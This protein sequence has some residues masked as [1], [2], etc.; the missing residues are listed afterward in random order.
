MRERLRD[1]GGAGRE[2]LLIVLAVDAARWQ[3]VDASELTDL[4][5]VVSYNIQNVYIKF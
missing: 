2:P 4:H 5:D 1:R 3:Q